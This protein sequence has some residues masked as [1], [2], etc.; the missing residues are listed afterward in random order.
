MKLV[1]KMVKFCI[2][3]QHFALAPSPIED[4]YF[5]DSFTGCGRFGDIFGP[6]LNIPERQK[7]FQ[8]VA[9]IVLILLNCGV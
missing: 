4:L 8:C 1:I 9:V 5:D 2:S 6:N 3:R 7:D